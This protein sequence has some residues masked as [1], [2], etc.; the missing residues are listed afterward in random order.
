MYIY[1]KE[2]PALFTE[3]GSV[4]FIKVRDRVQQLLAVSGAAMMTKII[5]GFIGI[6]MWLLMACVDRLIETNEI[7]E[8]K[9]DCY[10]QYR[11]FVSAKN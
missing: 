9:R 1:E 2:K 11:V 5:T 6:D 4:I 10:G 7:V 8:L 3:K